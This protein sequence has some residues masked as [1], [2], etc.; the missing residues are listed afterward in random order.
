MKL[1]PSIFSI[2]PD[3]KMITCFIISTLVELE[4]ITYKE[5]VIIGLIGKIGEKVV[6]FPLL[7]CRPPL[8]SLAI[9]L[10]LLNK[11]PVQGPSHSSQ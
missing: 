2:S 5:L 3:S 7:N 10:R 4:E 11:S 1:V 6:Q 8:M 9:K